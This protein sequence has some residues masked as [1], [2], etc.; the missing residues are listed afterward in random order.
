ME[1]DQTCRP[2]ERCHDRLLTAQ[3]TDSLAHQ[4]TMESDRVTIP[5]VFQH[6]HSYP[7][8]SHTQSDIEHYMDSEMAIANWMIDKL[9]HSG[10]AIFYWLLGISWKGRVANEEVG[11]R[12][13]Q[14]SMDDILSERRLRWLGHVIRMDHQRIPRHSGVALEGSGI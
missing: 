5:A 7:D 14:R 2:A 6:L 13:G 12:T 3:S 1:S 9:P 4:M 8:N 10:I 11:V